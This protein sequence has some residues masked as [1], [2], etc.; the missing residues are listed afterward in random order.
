M[1]SEGGTGENQSYVTHLNFKVVLTFFAKICVFKKS[2]FSKYSPKKIS[3]RPHWT[4]TLLDFV[5]TTVLSGN[6]PT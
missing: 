3:F 5:R 4:S 2:L 6:R 1:I